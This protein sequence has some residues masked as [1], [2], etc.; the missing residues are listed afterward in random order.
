MNVPTLRRAFRN[1]GFHV[2][3]LHQPVVDYL[4]LRQAVASALLKLDEEAQ[5]VAESLRIRPDEAW[6]RVM[7]PDLY[8]A[9][10]RFIRALLTLSAWRRTAAPAPRETASPSPEHREDKPWR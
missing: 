2:P 6:E 3:V 7:A 8:L 4:A 10:E 5:R 1:I 9:R